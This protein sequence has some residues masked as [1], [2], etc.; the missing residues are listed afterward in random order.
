MKKKKYKIKREDQSIPFVVII[1]PKDTSGAIQTHL[2][3]T[4]IVSC[5]ARIMA[6]HVSQ[7][8]NQ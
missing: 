5:G 7:S 6:A 4:S 1:F 8:L 2:T 3:I